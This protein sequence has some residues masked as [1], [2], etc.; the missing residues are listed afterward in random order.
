MSGCPDCERYDKQI[1]EL[2]EKYALL[3]RQLEAFDR[4]KEKDGFIKHI[5]WFIRKLLGK[6]NHG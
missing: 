2:K 5:A 1:K 6:I 4:P 3:E